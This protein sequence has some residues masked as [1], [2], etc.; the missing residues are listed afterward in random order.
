MSVRVE[1]LPIDEFL[2]SGLEVLKS[3][4]LDGGD[5]VLVV[6]YRRSRRMSR[7]AMAGRTRGGG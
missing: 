4:A 3:D 2:D 7:F 5:L 6:C 1:G